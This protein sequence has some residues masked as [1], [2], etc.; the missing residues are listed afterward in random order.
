MKNSKTGVL[1]MALLFGGLI[2]LGGCT[3]APA[4]VTNEITT[5]NK[6][7][8]DA[9]EKADIPLLTANYMNDAK[10]MPANSE[11]ITGKDAIGGF[12]QAVMGMGIKK[13]VFETATAESYGETAIEEGSYQLIVEGNHVVDQGKYIATWKK[14]GDKWKIYRDIFNTN[15]PAPAVRASVNDTVMVVWNTIKPGMVQQ[16]EDFNNNYLFPAAMEMNPKSASTVRILKSVNPDK[17][18]NITYFYLMD[19]AIDPNYYRMDVPL[20]AKYGKEKATE[21]MKIIGDCL[22]EGGSGFEITVQIS[23]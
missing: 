13:V 23:K 4:D 3:P 7:L 17:E 10:L 8:M 16:F 12:F 11:A 15:N 21:Y 1:F 20:V 2:L 14:E 18:G 22:K 19:P 5:A 9:F 6:A